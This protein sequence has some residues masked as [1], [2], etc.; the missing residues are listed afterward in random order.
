MI[1]MGESI[2]HKRVDIVRHGYLCN[3]VESFMIDNECGVSSRVFWILVHDK[4]D[5]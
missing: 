2:R 4:L 3:N 1:M 5:Y